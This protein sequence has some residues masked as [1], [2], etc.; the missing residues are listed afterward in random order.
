SRSVT[1]LTRGDQ[2]EQHPVWSPDGKSIAFLSKRG[3]DAD[4][5]SSW[6]VYVIPAAAGGE[7]R[8]LTRFDGAVDNP[9][10]DHGIAWSPDGRQIAFLQGGAPKL[11]YYVPLR[12]AV[13]PAAGG[14]VRVLTRDLDREISE[15]AWAP[16]SRSLLGI[17]EDDRARRLVRVPV[18]GGRPETLLGGPRV[19]SAFDV[20][21]SGRIAVLTCTAA[22]V[23]EVYALEGSEPRQ[24]SHQ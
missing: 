14:A 13:V 23:S 6:E 18:Q 19:V 22:T 9:D 4:R 20:A 15:I 21:P 5:T 11:I 12:L 3:D 7:A 16:D 10:A 8:Q 24:L 17:V 1:Q 2:D